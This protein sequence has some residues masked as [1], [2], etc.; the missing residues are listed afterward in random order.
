MEKFNAGYYCI[1][2]LSESDRVWLEQHDYYLSFYF[3][4]HYV[5]FV[6]YLENIEDLFF[7]KLRF[8][9]RLHYFDL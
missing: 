1:I 4:A 9:N 5:F 2:N 6:V 7:L 8:E 3:L